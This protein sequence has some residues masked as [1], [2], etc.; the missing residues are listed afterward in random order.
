[1]AKSELTAKN[2]F[3]TV[4]Q[5]WDVTQTIQIIEDQRALDRAKINNLFNGK[6]PYTPAEEE[7]NN[8]MINVNW[9]YGKNI[10]RDA[11]AQLNKA[12]NHK[13]ILFSCS[14][15]E[16]RV[17][18]RDEWS[19][20]FTNLI[21]KPLKD[22]KSGLLHY[23]LLKQR[24]S[25][26]AMH[27]IGAMLWPNDFKWMPR[28]LAL[29][30]LLIP[31]ETYCDFSNLRYFGVNYY[32]TPGELSKMTQGDKV[33]PGWNKEMVQQILK[34]QVGNYAEGTPSTWRDQ[35]E[36]MTQ[37]YKENSGWYTSDIV[38][39]IKLRGFYYTR[40]D[41]PDK[42]YRNIM[43]REAYG[44]AKVG[45]QFLF[46]GTQASFADDIGQILSV[47]YGDNNFVAPLK[48]HAVRGIGV[49]LF[50]AVETLNRLQCELVQH[51]LEQ[52]KMYFR[53]QDPQDRDRLKQVVLSAYG[54]IPEGL[55]IVPRDQRHQID[56]N[57]V[58][59]SMSLI[60]QN[61]QETS[62]AYVSDPDNG[63]EKEMTAREAMIKLNQANAMVSGMMDSVLMQEAFYYQEVVRRF[64]NPTTTDPQV[65]KFQADCI[66][67]GIPKELI[68]AD[69]WKVVPE[70]VLGGGDKTQ[71]QSEAEYLMG[72]RQYLSPTSQQK[73]DRLVIS[74]VLNDPS[75]AENLVP[76]APPTTTAG[77]MAAEDVFA[78]LMT[79]NQCAPREGIE[80]ADYVAAA[81]QM[82]AE[83]VMRIQKTDN[84]GTPAEILG[85]NTVSQNIQTHLQIMESDPANKQK[86]KLSADALGNLSNE[87]KGFQQR[88]QQ[89]AQAAQAQSSQN[90]EMQAKVQAVQQQA[91]VKAQT[92]Q[93]ASE[94]KIAQN[95]A[96]FEQK[97]AHQQQQF[98]QK[99]QQEAARNMAEMQKMLDTAKADMIAA[100]LK[101][102]QELSHK[103]AH[104]TVDIA[105]KKKQAKAMPKKV[106]GGK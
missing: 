11:N 4:Q 39:K 31:T 90:P 71:A 94:Q 29:E 105:I 74:T 34:S 6:I 35:P 15:Q 67:Y 64:C 97:I 54:M 86:V 2:E 59:Q 49:D 30:D 88:Q 100:G 16:G 12:T 60:R 83:V 92:S 3:G 77:R 40:V 42:W 79:G 103:D 98:E 63:T 33:K 81:I 24:N 47:Q 55:Q 44:D 96:K 37:I 41:Q 61:M 89:A 80:E 75:K 76:Y 85:L 93:A 21:N 19:Q 69:A 7:K 91:Q 66:K 58:N 43:L 78:T 1:M 62:S 10:A 56:P 25:T 73:V 99:M 22:G 14:A 28:F 95:E 23:Y 38:P 102:G 32:L 82:M 17:D 70:R 65:K 26:L 50:A 48:Y 101:T 36:A 87:I 51:T 45:E 20:Y 68:K 106:D 8:I 27:G 13:G 84:M 104:A 18:K 57:L 5:C 72:M 9:G 52:L 53:I 46:D